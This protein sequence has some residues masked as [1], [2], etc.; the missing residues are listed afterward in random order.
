M[1]LNPTGMHGV[2]HNFPEASLPVGCMEE[3]DD[4]CLQQLQVNPDCHP[5]AEFCEA[6]YHDTKAT[7]ELTVMFMPFFVTKRCSNTIRIRPWDKWYYVLVQG[8]G[9]N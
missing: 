5:V 2:C 3:G 9:K 1:I 6:P 4:H 8:K 7:H